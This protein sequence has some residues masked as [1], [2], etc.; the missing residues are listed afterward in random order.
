MT[1]VPLPPGQLGVTFSGSPPI[2]TDVVPD[3]PMRSKLSIG[4][5]IYGVAV[6]HR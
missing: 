6:P 2:V 4:D 5:V 1:R 3:S